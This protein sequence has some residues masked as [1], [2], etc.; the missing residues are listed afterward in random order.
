MAVPSRK[1]P[2]VPDVLREKYRDY[3][4]REEERKME[5]ER[6]SKEDSPMEE[7]YSKEDK[8]ALED[9]VNEPPQG[10]AKGGMV[11]AGRSGRGDGKCIKGFTKGKVY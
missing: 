11:K 5:E 10:Y 8:K 6:S 4:K 1:S 3:K 9:L 2:M 7:R